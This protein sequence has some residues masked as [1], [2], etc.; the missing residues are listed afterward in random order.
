MQGVK[1]AVGQHARK[2][3]AHRAARADGCA[4]YEIVPL[5]DVERL[6]VLGLADEL[7]IS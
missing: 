7:D 6:K 2:S 3:C 1:R 5:E 4:D